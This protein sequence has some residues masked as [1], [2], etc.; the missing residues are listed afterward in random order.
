VDVSVEREVDGR[1]LVKLATDEWEV[2]VRLSEEDVAALAGIRSGSWSERRTV[3]AGESVGAP[4][5]WASEDA[6]GTLLIVQDDETW[7]MRLPS[8]CRPSTGSSGRPCGIR[9]ECL[10]ECIDTGHGTRASARQRQPVDD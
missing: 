1:L 5:F 6:E 8:R 3:C 4:V 7:D 2:N 9:S 10:R